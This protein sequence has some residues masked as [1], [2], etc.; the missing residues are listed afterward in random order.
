MIEESDTG[1]NLSNLLSGF[2]VFVTDPDLPPNVL[3]AALSALSRPSSE[4]SVSLL[5]YPCDYAERTGL[6]TEK[7]QYLLWIIRIQRLYEYYDY[8]RRRFRLRLN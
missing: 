1:L 4:S 3:L 6:S 5:V 2:K 7:K 8:L